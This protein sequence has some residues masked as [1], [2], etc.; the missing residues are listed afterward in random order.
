MALHRTLIG[1]SMVIAAWVPGCDVGRGEEVRDDSEATDVDASPLPELTYDLIRVTDVSEAGETQG[2]RFDAVCVDTA[3]ENVFYGFRVLLIEF[4]DNVLADAAEGT[5]RLRPMSVDPWPQP[6]VCRLDREPW[7]LEP[8]TPI[9]VDGFF[10]LQMSQPVMDGDILRPVDCSGPATRYRVEL[11]AVHP[12]FAVDD[13]DWFY[14]EQRGHV[15]WID[16]GEY[17]GS[18]L[19]ETGNEIGSL[20]EI[21]VPELPPWQ[22]E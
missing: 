11:G 8:S 14:G 5:I 2:T 10:V 13:F 15:Q 19:T 4:G 1:F 6:D 18:M 7:D 16:L 3:D 17:S 22:G 21:V 20:P 9:G 12:D